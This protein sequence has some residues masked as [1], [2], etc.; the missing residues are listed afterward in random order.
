VSRPRLL[1]QLTSF[2][3]HPFIL[4]SAPAGYGKTTLVTDWLAN[5]DWPNAWLSLDENDNELAIFLAYLTKAIRTV[6]PDACPETV[7]LLR[8]VTLPA[9]RIVS[10]TLINDLERINQHFVVVLDDYHAIHNVA[11]NELIKQLLHH[12]PSHLQLVIMTRRD[13]LLPLSR[14]RAQ[15]RMA[16]I[17]A[18]ELGFTQSEVATLIQQM[19]DRA[20]D[21]SV[22]ERLASQSEGWIA[23]LRLALLASFHKDAPAHTPSKEPV[24]GRYTI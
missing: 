10:A 22:V 1:Q 13:P 11:I 24:G 17:R 4:I 21:A 5:H 16:E 12:P 6:F 2:G 15:G 3:A 18:Q 19:T 9:E 23:G 20:A 7:D 14:Y 8:L